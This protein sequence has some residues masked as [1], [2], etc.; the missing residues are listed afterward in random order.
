MTMS[1]PLYLGLSICLSL[2]TAC[3]PVG[4][5]RAFWAVESLYDRLRQPDSAHALA[6]ILFESR[7]QEA[8]SQAIST[9]VGMQMCE[10][11]LG[12]RNKAEQIRTPSEKTAE[13][14]RLYVQ[15]QAAAGGL[16]GVA[17]TWEGEVNQPAPAPR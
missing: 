13:Q 2:R 11:A 12:L 14:F 15:Q 9:A 16:L 1:K 8:S 10:A 17:G 3:L 5:G 4:C 6:M 7:M